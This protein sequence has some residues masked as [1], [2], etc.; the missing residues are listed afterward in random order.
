VGPDRETRFRQLYDAARPQLLKYALR[1][2][3]SPEDAADVV[4]ETFAI[5]WRRL[6]DVPDEKQ[7]LLWLYVTA[8]NVI[9]NGIRRKRRGSELVEQLICQLSSS[10]GLWVEPLDEEGMVASLL[11][12]GLPEDEREVLM[13]ASWEGLRSAELG[14]VLGCSPLAARLRL[15]RARARL[16]TEMSEFEDGAKHTNPARHERSRTGQRAPRK[17]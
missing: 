9:A 4:A 14:R 16:V 2:T 13:L 15:H 7:G 1:R 17:V 11:L 5:A 10:K 3:S 6:D 12:A 8:R